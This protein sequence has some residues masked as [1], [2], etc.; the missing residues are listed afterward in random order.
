M[1]MWEDHREQSLGPR[2]NAWRET[3]GR[4]AG[5]VR[6]Q[7]ALFKG[8]CLGGQERGRIDKVL[9]KKEGSDQ[10][11]V[12]ISGAERRSRYRLKQRGWG[13]VNGTR[14]GLPTDWGGAD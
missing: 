3:A 9:Q 4:R 13:A 11:E 10:K 7:T 14:D 2:S 8:K 12:R 5:Y 1:G 6:P